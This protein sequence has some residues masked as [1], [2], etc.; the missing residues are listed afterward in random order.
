M[1]CGHPF[2]FFYSCLVSRLGGL[3]WF[4][5]MLSFTDHQKM[6]GPIEPASRSHPLYHAFFPIASLPNEKCRR[7][8]RRKKRQQPHEC[9]RELTAATRGPIPN[10]SP[11]AEIQLV[12]IVIL[13]PLA[14]AA[15]LDSVPPSPNGIVHVL[16]S[17][18]QLLILAISAT[19]VRKP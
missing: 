8:R 3:V 12:N 16:L 7:R 11:I 6:T 4:K 1:G 13:S 9:K 5:K 15:K 19:K 14:A 10:S 17:T 2:F 18:L